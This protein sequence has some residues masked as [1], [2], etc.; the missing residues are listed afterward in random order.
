MEIFF[1]PGLDE[2]EGGSQAETLCSMPGARGTPGAE[3]GHGG[4]P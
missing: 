1:V 4:Y 2:A 3:V